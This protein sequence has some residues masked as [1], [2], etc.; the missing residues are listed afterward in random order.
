VRRRAL[1][2]ALG[3]GALLGR[4]QQSPR[5]RCV[6]T[7]GG[8]GPGSR[9]AASVASSSGARQAP[10][11][12]PWCYAVQSRRAGTASVVLQAETVCR[13]QL[14]ASR[15]GLA[16]RAPTAVLAMRVRS[17]PMRPRPLLPCASLGATPCQASQ[18]V[19]I[20]LVVTR[21]LLVR[22]HRR[23]AATCA[24]W[25]RTRCLGKWPA[26]TAAQDTCAATGRRH[27]RRRLASVRPVDIASRASSVARCVIAPAAHC[28]V[29][30]VERHCGGWFCVP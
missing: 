22:F 16:W 2:A 19:R 17:A 8:P 10:Q 5:L 6:R 12:T 24:A 14:A 30:L 25:A 28:Y 27:Q 9:R 13:V 1:T 18:R 3:T 11:T 7:V 4:R 26:K 23:R 15:R 29:P 21:A 20:A